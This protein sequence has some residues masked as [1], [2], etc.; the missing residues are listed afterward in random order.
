MTAGMHMLPCRHRLVPERESFCWRETARMTEDGRALL[1]HAREGGPVRCGPALAVACPFREWSEASTK[2]GMVPCPHCRRRHRQGSNSQQLCEAWSSVKRELA[3]MRK[4][5]PPAHRYYDEGTSVLPYEE[6]TTALV[7][8][9]VWQRLKTAVLRRDGYRCQDCGASF[10][11]R[12]R[13]VYDPRARRG[14]G[15]YRRE[16]LEVHHIVPRACGGSDHPGNLKT[17]C[18]G[19]HRQYTEELVSDLTV[20]RRERREQYRELQ[21]LGYEDGQE[22]DPRDD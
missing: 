10:N 8:R 17:L 15:G 21:K 22:Y 3:R 1:F 4:E 5:R 19:C 20:R 6:H 16:S 9:L 14:K 2:A 18:P 13:K 12:S 11:G 7:R